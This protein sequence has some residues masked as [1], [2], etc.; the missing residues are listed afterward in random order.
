MPTPSA[1]LLMQSDRL[2]STLLSLAD[3]AEAHAVVAL[4]GADGIVQLQHSGGSDVLLGAG[5]SALIKARAIALEGAPE[6]EGCAAKVRR[7]EAALE[8]LGIPRIFWRD[9]QGA[10]ASLS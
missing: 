10:P 4:I 3:E 9:L 6:C 7:T 5:A 2:Q 8:A 1:R